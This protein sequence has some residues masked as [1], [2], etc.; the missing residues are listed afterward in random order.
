MEKIPMTLANFLTEEISK[1]PDLQ[2]V[3]EET[4]KTEETPRLPVSRTIELAAQD[5]LVVID[6]QKQKS[7]LLTTKLNILFVVNGAFLTCLILSRLLLYPSVFSVIEI[8]GL[9]I[10]F[11]LLIAAFLPRQEAIS[12]NLED[13]K[14]LERYLALS[15]DE[16]QLKMIANHIATY[17]T[18]KQRL[19]DVS[20]SL[21]Y[22]AYVTWFIALS[23]MLQ[24]IA[25]YF[26]NKA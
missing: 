5:V 6:Q 2:L 13:R 16:Y 9:L 15:P 19:D 25:S 18:N 7:Y 4:R 17:N 24:I 12:P 8:I 11:S 26:V 23:V 14:F 3:P 1:T 21:T 10:N 22:A 20:Q